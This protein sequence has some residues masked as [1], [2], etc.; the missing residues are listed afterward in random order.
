LIQFAS[1][2]VL[3]VAAILALRQLTYIRNTRTVEF[4]R[5]FKEF[6]LDEKHRKVRQTIYRN[7]PHPFAESKAHE[8][9]LSNLITNKT[10]LYH[11]IETEIYTIDW[12]AHM[13]RKSEINVNLVLEQWFDVIA[14][15]AVLLHR[16]IQ[17]EIKARRST[18]YAENFCWLARRNVE[19]IRGERGYLNPP[20]M[21]IREPEK[22]D[23]PISLSD[24]EKAARVLAPN[25]TVSD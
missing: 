24:L 7:V 17:S 3:T 13:I 12:L 23:L 10:Q 9:W 20:V 21:L 16:L 18:A 19:Y 22:S 11:K 15:L 8:R 1:L 2:I 14:R 25:P 4:L 5:D 6:M